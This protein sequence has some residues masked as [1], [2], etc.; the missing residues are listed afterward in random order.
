MFFILKYVKGIVTQWCIKFHTIQL[1]IWIDLEIRKE[2]SRETKSLQLKRILAVEEKKKKGWKK[3]KKTIY[4]QIKIY[5]LYLYSRCSLVH[6]H[7]HAGR[8]S[9]KQQS[10]YT[11][12]GRQYET[13]GV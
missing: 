10:L 13:E 7:S 2:R 12:L 3:E 9:C 6:L 4:M 11:H 8:H 5:Q 1:G